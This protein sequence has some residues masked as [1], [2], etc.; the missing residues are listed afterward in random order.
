[1]SFWVSRHSLALKEKGVELTIEEIMSIAAA[2]NNA[3]KEE[4]DE[5]ALEDVAG[6]VA[7]INVYWDYKKG[8]LN[9]TIIW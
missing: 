8:K 7:G 5:D 3:S 9:V 4:L 6:G 1:M 2:I